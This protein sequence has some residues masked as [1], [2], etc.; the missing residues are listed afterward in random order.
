MCGPKGSWGGGGICREVR[1]SECQSNLIGVHPCRGAG[2]PCREVTVICTNYTPV[3]VEDR[4]EKI[5]G[6]VCGMLMIEARGG[7]TKK[8]RQNGMKR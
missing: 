1:I 3:R 5:Y 2:N 6:R 4:Q 7:R 8:K